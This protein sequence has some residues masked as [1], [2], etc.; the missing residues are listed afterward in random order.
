M[1]V[2]EGGGGGRGGGQ[3]RGGEVC[4]K[5]LSVYNRAVF[6]RELGTESIQEITKVASLVKSCRKS[7]ISIHSFYNLTY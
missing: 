7:T 4:D 2:W 6:R 3:G 1:C 5:F